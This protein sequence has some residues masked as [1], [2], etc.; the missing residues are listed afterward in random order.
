MYEGK[1]LEAGK[2]S[3]SVS[4]ILKD[5]NKTLQEKEIEKSMSKIISCLEKELGASLR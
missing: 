4:M 1:S 3:Y 2:K 5:P